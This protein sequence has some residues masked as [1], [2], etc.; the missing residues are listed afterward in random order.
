MM[1]AVIGVIVCIIS[2]VI[3]ETA[4]AL[5]CVSNYHFSQSLDSPFVI[6]DQCKE[7]KESIISLCQVNLE[8]DYIQR[9]LRI[10]RTEIIKVFVMN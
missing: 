6:P 9:N 7:T 2:G 4:S 8:I 10:K 5:S 1:S 3:I